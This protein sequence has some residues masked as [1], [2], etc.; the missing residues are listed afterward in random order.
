MNTIFEKN[1][2]KAHL[3][4][5]LYKDLKKHKAIIAGGMITSL[6]TNK[7]INDVD[8]YFRDNDNMYLFAERAIEDNYVVAH[9]KKATQFINSLIYGKVIVQIIHYRTYKKVEDIFDTY[10]FTVCMGAFDFETEEFVLH[11]D[12]LKHNAQR[13]LR[14]NSKTS[15]PLISAIRTQKYENKG[16]SLSKAEYFRILMTCMTLNITS[17]EELKEQL[18]G[19]YG[20]SYDRLFEDV[21]DEEFDLQTAIDKIANITLAEDYFK[22]FKPVEIGK[23]EILDDIDKG[24]R[25]V[26]ELL[27]DKYRVRNGEVAEEYES[28]K[29]YI[30]VDVN[31][32]YKGK[33]FYKFVK[34]DGGKL[35]S[36]WEND[37]VYTVGEEV[38]A[39]KEYKKSRYNH[40][41]GK[42]FFKRVN[43][44]H[45]ADQLNRDKRVLI[46]VEL[47]PSDIIEDDEREVTATKCKVVRV[48]PEEEWM[49]LVEKLKEN[50]SLGKVLN[51]LD[52][53]PF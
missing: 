11:P 40:G 18:G 34:Q 29:E 22:E 44:I 26:I 37:F 39:K 14:F 8:V 12:F 3:G 42:L 46:E 20:E 53:I 47:I 41:D 32:F 30:S 45:K 21:K 36:F 24:E 31:E 7:E 49:P 4:D 16:Y 17:Y 48:V 15:Y 50:D 28:D 6:F 38:K 52:E 35:R 2:L 23:D 9:T 25:Y 33:K 19:M 5:R 27:G 43:Q 51:R 13:I 10:D 1:R